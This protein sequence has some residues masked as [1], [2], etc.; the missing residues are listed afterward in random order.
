M[1]K[2]FN[3]VYVY[4][5]LLLLTI[6]LIYVSDITNLPENIVLFEGEPLNLKTV[7]G[8]NLK[9]A[10]SSNPNIERIENKQT[11]TVS[12]NSVNEDY[13]GNLNLE[14]SLLGVKV[15]EINVDIIENVE[16]VPLGKLI[17]VKLYTN[18]VLVVGMSEITGTDR[19]RYKPYEGTGINQGDIIVE[20]NDE[21]ITCTNEL[22]NC[23]NKSKGNEMNIKYIRGG[24]VLNTKLKAIR[25]SNE[26]YK[27]G[28][29]VRDTA[30]GVGTAT[31]Y[32]GKSKKFAS[33]GHGIIDND[34]EELVEIASR[35]YCNSQYFIYSKRN[36]RKSTERYRAQ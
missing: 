1:K 10:F 22:T 20:V 19:E 34:T 7:L 24:E 14:V 26:T 6:A 29:W 30:A 31:F 27:I 17:G 36:R 13:T 33:L 9:T 32:E 28:L 5:F 8:V 12:S 16:V 25:T 4:I 23:I 18:G 15:K 2:V 11:I 35:R 21:I 3:K